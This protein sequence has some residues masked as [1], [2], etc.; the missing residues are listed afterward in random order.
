M[1]QVVD[2]GRIKM[3][4][5]DDHAVVGEGICQIFEGEPDLE[6]GRQT[7][8]GYLL[9]GVRGEELIDAVQKEILSMGNTR[10]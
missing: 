5:A 9:K 3:L 8:A 2:I 1:T 7:A 4:I 10:I 6:G